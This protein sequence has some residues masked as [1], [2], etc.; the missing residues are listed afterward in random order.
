M[1]PHGIVLAAVFVLGL[2]PALAQN[3]PVASARATIETIS[4]D[5][6]SLGGQNA[7]G[8]GANHSPQPED[9]FRPW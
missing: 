1:A 5:G 7:G 6:A 4:A 9:Q 8:R 2:T 3:A